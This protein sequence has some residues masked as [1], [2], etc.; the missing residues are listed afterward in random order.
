MSITKWIQL[1]HGDDGLK[2]FFQK[3][4][5]CIK[6]GGALILEPQEFNTFERRA[7]EDEAS[8]PIRCS[9]TSVG[10]LNIFG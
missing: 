1:H 8:I 10:V 3:T 2:R 7:K 4:Y 6:P 5:N 9:S